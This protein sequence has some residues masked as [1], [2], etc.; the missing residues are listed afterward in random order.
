MWLCHL[1]KLKL[2][3]K[4][5]LNYSNAADAS[6]SNSV[7]VA[8]VPISANLPFNQHGS[9]CSK[10]IDSTCS[11]EKH[12]SGPQAQLFAAVGPNSCHLLLLSS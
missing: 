9:C 11:T 3:L 8:H 5:K 2:K 7:G 12:E 6:A 1:P 10:T 4:L